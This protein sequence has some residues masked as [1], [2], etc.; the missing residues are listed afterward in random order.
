MKATLLVRSRIAYS[1][2]A[3]SEVVV[4]RLPQ[5]APGSEHPYKYRLA[6]IVN[7][8]CILRIDNEA[9]KGDHRHIRGREHK[10]RFQSIERLLSDFQAEVW[11]LTN[12]NRNT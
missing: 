5:A 8:E 3:F 9:G 2:T 7:G 4:W 1:D 10:Y 11:R 12:E 6:Y